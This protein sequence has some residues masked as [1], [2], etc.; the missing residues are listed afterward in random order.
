MKR[1][2]VLQKGSW[3][4]G[5]LS[6]G[7][8]SS[9]WVNTSA[10]AQGTAK[11]LTAKDI[12]KEGKPASIA[13]YCENA[14]KQPNK[15]CPDAKPGN[16]CENCQFYNTDKSETTFEGVKVAKC[17]LLANPASAQYVAAAGWCATYVPKAK[18]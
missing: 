11:K 1:R 17:T 3:V 18:T 15:Y 9:F 2:D 12:L 14:K 10:W 8:L 5:A 16:I 4:L 6:I 7:S 13:N